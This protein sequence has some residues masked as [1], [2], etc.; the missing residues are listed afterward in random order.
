LDRWFILLRIALTRIFLLRFLF[1]LDSET[2]GLF[3]LHSETAD[4]DDERRVRFIVIRNNEGTV[5]H[6]DKFDQVSVKPTNVVTS[7]STS[8]SPSMASLLQAATANPSLVDVSLGKASTAS[9]DGDGPFPLPQGVTM[10]AWKD[11]KST[12][13]T[14]KSSKVIS[15]KGEKSANTILGVDTDGNFDAFVIVTDIGQDG[16][17]CVVA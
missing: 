8:S 17:R 6:C 2:A 3:L 10:Y 16:K 14:I 5:V 15:L 9:S 12:K 13:L 7:P 11:G 1:L 4:D